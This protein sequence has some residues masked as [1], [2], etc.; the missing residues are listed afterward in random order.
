MA[1]QT[2]K[3]RADSKW[4]SRQTLAILSNSRAGNASN[5][6][7][8]Q[9]VKMRRLRKPPD[10]HKSTPGN[11]LGALKHDCGSNPCPIGI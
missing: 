2:A 1:F 10:T 4:P 7:A 3:A 11:A 5:Y 8:R 6:Y 9:R